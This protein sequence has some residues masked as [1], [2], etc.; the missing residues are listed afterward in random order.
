MTL[1]T[2]SSLVIC[3]QEAA[4]TA[5]APYK[6]NGDSLYV[7]PYVTPLYVTPLCDPLYVM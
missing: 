6:D 2:L 5:R 7:T 4:Y 1:T 3:V